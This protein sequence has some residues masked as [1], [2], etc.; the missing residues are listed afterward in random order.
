LCRVNNVS[1]PLCP[2]VPQAP[3]DKSLLARFR[4]GHDDA[5]TELYRRYAPRLHG[6]LQ[7]QCSSGLA[8]RVDA[9]DIVQ[10]VF[11][12][13][14]ERARKGFYDIPDGAN[15]WQLIMVIALNKLRTKRSFH[16]AARRDV[17]RTAPEDHLD[18]RCEQTDA[19]GA[20]LRLAFDEAMAR[21]KDQDQRMVELLIEGHEVAEI[22]TALGRSKRTVE[23]NL[24]AVRQKLSWLLEEDLRHGQ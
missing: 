11:C 4:H 9:D 15:F 1:K 8:R 6:L 5:A 19:G 14:F 2:P 12:A 16:H 20:L 10:S 18:A 17:R 7:Q 23:R 13:F 22:A 3:S 21:L 24:Q